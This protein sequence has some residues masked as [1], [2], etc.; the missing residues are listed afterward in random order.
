MIR[1]GAVTSGPF[2]SSGVTDSYGPY[3]VVSN[4][5]ETVGHGGGTKTLY[6]CEIP[7]G[8]GTQ[9]IRVFSSGMLTRPLQ[10][11]TTTCWLTYQVEAV[12]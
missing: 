12:P 11:L 6:K 5:P 9:R 7:L 10:L 3:L 2:P 4:S 1:T 8:T